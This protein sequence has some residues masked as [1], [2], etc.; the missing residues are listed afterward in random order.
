MAENVIDTLVRVEASV[1]RLERIL[2]GDPDARHTGMVT[3]IDGLRRDMTAIS[4][5]I[6]RMQQRRANPLLWM[7]GYVTFLASGAFAINA[8]WQHPQLRALLDMPA[9]L[10]LWLALFFA[11]A[12]ALLLVSGFGWLESGR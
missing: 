1:A 6:Q 10:A 7:A 8:F 4:A 5:D 9:P 3:Q 12:A 2:L 11:A